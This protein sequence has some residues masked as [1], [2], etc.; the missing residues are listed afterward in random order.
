V[1]DADEDVLEGVA[2]MAAGGT[3][4]VEVAVIDVAA[5]VV[6]MAVSHG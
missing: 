5:G 4:V 3:F 1:E 6:L 2:T